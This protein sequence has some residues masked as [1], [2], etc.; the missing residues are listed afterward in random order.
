[1]GGVP[2]TPGSILTAQALEKWRRWKASRPPPSRSGAWHT[3]YE[4]TTDWLLAREG[5]LLLGMVLASLLGLGASTYMQHRQED[6]CRHEEIEQ[7][8]RQL[9]GP[10]ARCVKRISTPN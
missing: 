5:P 7:M 2:R 8:R 6:L 3:A 1:M 9:L 4:A 10:Q